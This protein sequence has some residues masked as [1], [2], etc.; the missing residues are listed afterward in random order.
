MRG[1]EMR[2]ALVL[3]IVVTLLSAP[4]AA[5]PVTAAGET[6]VSVTGVDTVTVG[7]TTAAT[8]TATNVTGAGVGAFT[9]EV[10][11]DAV[12]VSVSVASTSGF[13][14]ET[15]TPSAGTL[16]IVGY[17]D[18][19]TGPIGDVS[20]ASLSVTGTQ[21]GDT[22]VA[23]VVETFT[24]A[25]GDD[26]RHLAAPTSLSV[27]SGE[28]GSSSGTGSGET[29]DDG[30]DDGTDDRAGGDGDN[31]NDG[32]DDG[33]DQTDAA[34]GGGVDADGSEDSDAPPADSV[35][36]QT[37]LV[38]GRVAVDI[39]NARPDE[40]VIVSLPESV[41]SD[42]GSLS[43]LRVTFSD[44]GV[45]SLSV[46]SPS[47]PPAE[48]SSL[49]VDG[50][51]LS[52]FD[53][54]HDINDSLLAS[55]DFSLTVSK[56]RLDERGLTAANLRLYRYHDGKWQ[57]LPTR[58][59]GETAA[60]I[61]LLA[62]SPGLSVFA[63]AAGPSAASLGVTDVSIGASEVSPGE[64]V[65]IVATVE[66]VG[67][68]GGLSTVDLRVDGEQRTSRVVQ[69]GAGESRTVEFVV[70]FDEQ[71]RYEITV[72]GV[73]AESVSVSEPPDAADSS[74]DEVVT[75]SPESA[76]DAFPIASAVGTLLVVAVVIL[77]GV[78]VAR[79]RGNG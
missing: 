45:G 34:L 12:D 4:L 6:T 59:V 33:T 32:G 30:G 53:V 42:D 78:W 47:E 49:N 46:G 38:D 75:T 8:L 51:V 3:L 26:I 76:P 23:V 24:D 29:P 66:N 41:G 62:R 63:L 50:G 70:A 40:A 16:R 14:V 15:S 27:G 73:S 72:A 9:I 10:Q 36:V 22:S 79:R 52:Y 60:D 68:Q 58:V 21:A 18:A 61:E 25:D 39:N 37:N 2:G 28:S 35:S 43:E 48:S 44:G 74:S 67:G 65:T 13:A 19:K 69:L 57:A 11:Y 56:T 64:S 77:L 5:V 31:G 17:T 71:G 54:A 1:P 55:V 7:N 20:L